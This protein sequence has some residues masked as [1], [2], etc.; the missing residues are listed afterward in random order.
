MMADYRLIQ[1]DCIESMKALPAN[2]VQCC[3][4]SPPYLNLRSYLPNDH[5]DKGKEIGFA[6]TPEEYVAKLVDVFREVRRLLKEDGTLWLNLAASWNGSGGA[7][8][9]YGAGGL[10]EGQPKFKGNKA[11]GY[12]P[13][14]MIPV[15]WLVA[16][17]LQQD[18]WWLRSDIIWH[19]LAPMP[20]SY[21][22][23]PTVAHE[24]LFLLTKSADYYYDADA[25][26]EQAVG[27]EPANVTHK[28][29][30]GEGIVLGRKTNPNGGLLNMKA[31]TSRNRRSV[32]TLGPES[33]GV[34]H[35]ATMPTK[36]VEPCILAGSKPGDTVLDPFNGAATV[37]VVALRHLRNYIGIELYERNIELSQRR[38]ERTTPML[39]EVTP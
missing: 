35:Y 18:G 7:G 13:K 33:S 4:T 38:I 15:P 30:R 14:D 34:E 2:S 29:Q 3:V 32:W 24:Y 37:G 8:G 11:A 23:R 5:P 28:H 39:L 31:A 1:G 21:S 19:K 22:D 20:A 36:L 12:K 9:D 6:Q 26:A 25:I 27:N 16:I 17:A 10:R